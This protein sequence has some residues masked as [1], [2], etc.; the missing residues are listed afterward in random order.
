MY[1]YLFIY[2]SISIYL[3]FYLFIEADV[4]MRWGAAEKRGRAGRDD[5]QRTGGRVRESRPRRPGRVPSLAG[6]L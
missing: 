5:V 4:L 2:L 6:P 1:I 3:S